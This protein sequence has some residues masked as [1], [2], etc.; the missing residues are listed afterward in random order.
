[1]GLTRESRIDNDVSRGLATKIEF[2]P[3]GSRTVAI[4]FE[5][6]FWNRARCCAS[7]DDVIREMHIDYGVTLEIDAYGRITVV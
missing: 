1:M 6:I 4:D 7:I 5:S 3:F 2:G